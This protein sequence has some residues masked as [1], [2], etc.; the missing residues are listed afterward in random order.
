M[1]KYIITLSALS[2][3]SILRTS[4]AWAEPTVEKFDL[5][6][7]K[8][9][10]QMKEINYSYIPYRITNMPNLK[11]IYQDSVVLSSSESYRTQALKVL[12]NSLDREMCT[13]G[14]HKKIEIDIS[15]IDIS[16]GVTKPIKK[17]RRSV[18]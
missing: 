2:L 16:M 6:T 13:G 4:T 9:E 15:Y 12:L 10:S 8:I 17:N 5:G 1:G 14:K 7:C 18:L 3:I 11:S